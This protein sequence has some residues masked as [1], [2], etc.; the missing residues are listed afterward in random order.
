MFERRAF[1]DGDVLC[2]AGEPATCMYAVASGEIEVL[3]GG[4]AA[5]IASMRS[6]DIVGEYGLFLPEGR[7]ATLR[8]RGQTSVLELDYERFERFLM[9][10]PDSVL[11]L[12]ALT[13]R[14]LHERQSSAGAP[15]ATIRKDRKTAAT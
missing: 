9:A 13:V 2:R 11:S 5:P 10:F 3:L 8:A 15:T 1:D 6:G 14:R 7:T 12:M 4:D